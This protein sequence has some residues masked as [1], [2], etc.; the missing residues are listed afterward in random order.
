MAKFATWVTFTDDMARRLETRP[1]HRGYLTELLDSG[2]LFASGPFVDDTGALIIYEADS[3]EAAEALLAADPYSKTGG[4]I[5]SAVI[6]EWNR[7][8]PAE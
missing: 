2:K 7:V 8:F 4:I 1:I 3:Q 5:E 6:Q